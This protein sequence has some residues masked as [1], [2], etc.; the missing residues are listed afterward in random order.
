MFPG[1]VRCGRRSPPPQNGDTIIVPA[2]TY[3]LSN[4]QLDARAPA[5][6]I[7]GAGQGST[8]LQGGGSDRVMLINGN[9]SPVVLRDLT[10]TGGD[11]TK[12]GGGG[13]AAGSGG[14]VTLDDVTVSGNRDNPP[15][16]TC[17]TAG[18]CFNEGGGGIFS[19]QNLTLND[20]T[21]S[22]NSVDVALSNGDSG[23]GGILIEEVEADLTLND[24]T[25]TGNTATV[26]ADVGG[27]TNTDNNG[28]GGIYNDGLDLAITDSTVSGNTVTVNGAVQS[29]PG[30]RR[31][32]R[33]SVRHQH[34]PAGQHDLGQC[35]P[36][37]RRRQGRRWRRVR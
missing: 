22:D 29:E 17:A 15:A 32:R 28:G 18:G 25:V 21:V 30:G 37:S 34:A 35:R 12:T 4:G 27:P 3:K 23:G 36:W 9:S 2:G 33:V 1:R 10:I 16:G 14:G 19:G 6:T 26:T 20:S 8:V 13:I 7:D 24:S 5:T 31:R 11:T